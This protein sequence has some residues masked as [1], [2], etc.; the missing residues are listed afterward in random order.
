MRDLRVRF[1]F[2]LAMALLPLLVFT[3]WR[4][5][6]DYA[7]EKQNK[8][9]IVEDAALRTVAEVI[10][11]L[12]TTKAILNTT[13][14]T[15]TS[16]NCDT[17][18]KRVSDNF[19]SIYN[20]ILTDSLGNPICVVRPVRSKSLIKS[21]LSSLTPE[22]KFNIDLHE[23]GTSTDAPKNVVITSLAVFKDNE[24]QNVYR[25]GTDLLE[26][27]SFSTQSELLDDIHVSIFSRSGDFIIGK[28]ENLS[29]DV[30]QSWAK[31]V[32]ETGRHSATFE[33]EF[34]EERH[35]TI[36]PT[37]EAELFVALN[38]PH[39]TLLNI[40]HI[41]PISSALIPLLAWA[42]AFLAI[43]L[44]TNKLLIN[45]L[46][47]M[48]LAA[49]KFADGNYA[50][51]VGKLKDAPAQIQELA[52]T[53]DIMAQHI[54]ERDTKL[55]DSLSEK[56][57]L[58]REIHHRVKNNL[59]IIISLLNMQKRQLK[60]PTYTDAITETRNRINAIALVHKAL[61]ESDDIR[62]VEMAPFLTQ[63]ISQVGRALLTDKKNITVKVGIDC[64]PRDADRATTIAMFIV[65]AM[66]N[67]VKHGVPNGGHID[68]EVKDHLDETI[69]KVEDNGGRQKKT[70][71]TKPLQKGTGD[72]LMKGFARQLSGE[73]LGIETDDGY[74]ATLVFPKQ[75]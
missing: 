46:H 13:A 16:E 24:L 17:E 56:E 47:P 4:A 21:T 75:L 42:F 45:H 34:G 44:A 8:S 57:T 62:E 14:Q 65:E 64:M 27:S 2:V 48:N 52:G 39:N 41:H 63:L 5:F 67:C 49:K 22:N 71:E 15:V 36:I 74:Q 11:T 40:N 6:D 30:I 28:D 66:T 10:N 43:W 1:G 72:R 32:I 20:M 61:Y 12:D 3:I 19:P 23:F 35:I 26:I 69:V 68:I 58:L 25:A 54:S 18:L 73:Y 60:D 53:L 9:A 29:A 55:T 50:A 37:R 51:R 38:A 33:N 31:K 59:Q 70:L 7:S